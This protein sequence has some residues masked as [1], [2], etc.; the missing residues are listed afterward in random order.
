MIDE[1][2]L[3]DLRV[4]GSDGDIVGLLGIGAEWVVFELLQPDGQKIARS[5]RKNLLGF[6]I[7]EVSHFLTDEPGYDLD[8]VNRKLR[9]LMSAPSVDT[10][11]APYDRLYSGIIRDLATGGPQNLISQARAKMGWSAAEAIPFIL[12][13]KGVI[14]RIDEIAS[15]DSGEA[16][17]HETVTINGPSLPMTADRG[18]LA[19]W[20]KMMRDFLPEFNARLSAQGIPD[21][22]LKPDLLEANPLYVWGGAAMDG[23]FTDH[24]FTQAAEYLNGEFGEFPTHDAVVTYAQQAMFISHL[25][26]LYTKERLFVRL[27][28][29]SA[30]LGLDYPVTDQ[31]GK[32]M[33]YASS[34]LSRRT[35]EPSLHAVML[36]KGQR[37]G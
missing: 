4:S 5:F 19:S 20:G 2:W 3:R 11:I 18:D 1:L 29:L 28:K 26:A 17:S 16:D 15:L 14:R 31:D 30:V 37:P 25:L 32:T 8:R 7:R 36:G 22:S 34:L 35:D 13:T 23:F 6:H 27:V 24:E 33:I 10:M 12:G 21:P 9:R